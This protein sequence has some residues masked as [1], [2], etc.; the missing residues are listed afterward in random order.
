METTVEP[1]KAKRTRKKSESGVTKSQEDTAPKPIQLDRED[2]LTLSL[3]TEKSRRL[4]SEAARIQAER[5]ALE[6]ENLL[7]VQNLNTK[8]GVDMNG[9]SI[10]LDQGVARPRSSG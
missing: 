8:Y 9:F 2:V 3:I 6:Q 10:D 7:Y 4:E 5:R 1:G